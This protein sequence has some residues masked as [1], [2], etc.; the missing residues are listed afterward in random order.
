MVDWLLLLLLYHCCVCEV[1]QFTPIY[2]G[3]SHQLT[4]PVRRRDGSRKLDFDLYVKINQS[5]KD[6]QLSFRRWRQ[7]R[8]GR[9][10]LVTED[11]SKLLASCCSRLL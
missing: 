11:A 8:K 1:I 7:E 2:G 5:H 3:N 6:I 9:T 4:P 10:H